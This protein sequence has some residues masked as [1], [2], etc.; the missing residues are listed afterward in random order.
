M[1][2]L[3]MMLD[4]DKCIN[5]INTKLSSLESDRNYYLMLAQQCKSKIDSIRKDLKEKLKL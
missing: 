2:K 3:N 4:I 1:K 5:F